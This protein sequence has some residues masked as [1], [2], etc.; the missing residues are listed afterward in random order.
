[1]ET[2]R[3]PRPGAGGDSS[4]RRASVPSDRAGPTNPRRDTWQLRNEAALRQANRHYAGARPRA[5]GRAR[6]QPG[7]ALS[8]LPSRGRALYTANAAGT[9]RRLPPHP[10][11]PRPRS[12]AA[13]AAPGAA[14]CARTGRRAR[15]LGPTRPLLATPFLDQSRGQTRVKEVSQTFHRAFCPYRLA[16]ECVTGSPEE[17]E[18]LAARLAARLRTGD[19]VAV[20]GDLGAGKTTFVRGAARALGVREPV[21]SPTF[22]IGHRYDAPVPVAHLDLYRPPGAHPRGR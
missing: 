15:A 20:S 6:R 21:S 16:V 11:A 12:R 8:D 19:V 10:G 18:A 17:T 5:A 22:T 1:M 4:L 7:D 13:S 9:R 2:S 14:I 3:K